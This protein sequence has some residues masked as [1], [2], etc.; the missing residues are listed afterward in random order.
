MCIYKVR[1]VIFIAHIIDVL[2]SSKNLNELTL[3]LSHTNV[4]LG[5]PGVGVSI[6]LLN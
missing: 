2:Y 5:V 4:D 6:L 3:G 1:G